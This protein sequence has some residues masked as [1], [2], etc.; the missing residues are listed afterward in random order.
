MPLATCSLFSPISLKKPDPLSCLWGVFCC[1]WELQYFISNPYDIPLVNWTSNSSWY[2][3]CVWCCGYDAAFVLYSVFTLYLF[4][5][6][7]HIYF[8]CM[9]YLPCSSH[10]HALK[11]VVWDLEV[12]RYL[13]WFSLDVAF[14]SPISILSKFAQ[15][16]LLFNA[17]WIN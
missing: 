17:N 13:T 15:P 12:H 11:S 2:T 16:P 5:K 9:L 8:I 4:Y 6:L 10:N 1:V 14:T 7:S 3:D